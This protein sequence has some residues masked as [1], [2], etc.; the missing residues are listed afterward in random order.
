[1]LR[2][3]RV[4]SIESGRAE[5]ELDASNHCSSC[6]GVIGC[7]G[8]LSALFVARNTV[9]INLES[10]QLSVGQSVRLVA[11]DKMLLKMATFSY[12]LPLLAFIAGLVVA[13]TIGLHELLSVTVGFFSVVLSTL[14]IRSYKTLPP[15]TLL[16]LANR[17]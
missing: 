2:Q 11:D 3:G 14:A 7:G 4:V 10:D 12:G 6:S 9:R 1:M 5:I 15:E 8:W 17:Q 16:L 13:E